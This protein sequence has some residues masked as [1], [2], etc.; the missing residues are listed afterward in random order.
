MK[1]RDLIHFEAVTEVI[2]LVSADKKETAK[3][4]IETYVIS[5]RMADVILHRM[6]PNLKLDHTSK[7][8]GLLIVGNYGTG[9]SHLMSVITSIAEHADLLDSIR[10]PA[11]REELKSIAGKFKV[12]R[13]ETSALNVSLRDIVFSQLSSHLK[14]MGVQY[15]FP[16]SNQAV[17]NK[18]SLSDM[19]EKFN[20]VYPGMGLLIALD[21][22][23]DF[24]RAKDEKA[25]INDLNFLR[26]VGEVCETVPLRFIAGIQE[27]LFDNPRF[28]FVADSIQR[29]KSRFDQAAI[30]REDI[31]YVVSHRL[32]SKTSDQLVKIRKHLEKFTPLYAEMAERLDSFVELF[33]VHPAYL[34]VFEQVTIGE[35][36]ELLKALSQEM[37]KLLENDVPEDEPGL[38][39]YDSYWRMIAEDNAFRAIPDVRNVLDKTTVLGE[40]VRHAPETKD[41][42]AAAL[43]II[44]GLALHRLTVSDIYA[45]IGITPA[46]IR[47]RLCISLPIPEKDADFLLATV[48]TV[49]KAVSTAVNGQYISH[50]RENDQYY[51][52][53]KKDIDYDALITQ[54]SQ[55]LDKSTIDRYYFDVLVN[56]LEI[57]DSSYVP[58][59]RIWE[60]EIPW[61]GHGISRRGYIF[62]G[63]SNERSTAHPERDFYIHFLGIYGNGHAGLKPQLDEIYYSLA[64]E[65]EFT[66]QLKLYA[67]AVEMS[68]ISSGSNK[69]QY[70][71]KAQQNKT[72]LT[73]WLRENF[74][75]SFKVSHLD[76][77]FS[78]P[79]A[80]ALYKTAIRDTNFRDQVFALSSAML[81]PAFTDKFPQYPSFTGLDLTS[82]TLGSAAEAAIKAIGS[83]SAIRLAQVVL[84]GL[85]LGHFDN[86]QMKWTIESSPYASYYLD[87]V[88]K[89]KPG[90]VVNRLDLVEGEPGAERDRQ[91]RLEPELLLVVLLAVMRQGGLTL[92]IQGRHVFEPGQV[93]GLQFSLDQMMRFTSIS[94]PKPLPEQAIKELLT[95][96]GIDANILDDPGALTLGVT[97]LQKNIQDEM[98]TV[99]KLID[100]LRDGP[101]FWGELVLSKEEQLNARN[102]LD[103]Y[104]QFLTG[105]QSHTTPARL[106]NL[107]EGVGEIR[108]AVKTRNVVRDLQGIFAILNDLRPAWDYLAAAQ[109]L[110]PQGHAWQ[111]EL[112]T[113]RE[114]VVKTLSDGQKRAATGTS[115]QLRARLENVKASYARQYYEMHTAARLDR[116]QDEQKKAI[117]ADPRWVKMR[118]LSKLSL[119]PTRQLEEVQ[120]RIAG[121]ATCPNLQ[122]AE[123]KN[124]THCPQCGFNPAAAGND[125]GRAI[126]RLQEASAAFEV[127]CKS[128]VE[129]LLE[130][131]QSEEA[132]HN[133]LLVAENE[134]Q[135]VKEFLRTRTLPDPIKETF[136]SGVENTLQGLEVIAVD[137][138]DY[139]LALTQPGM[140]CT[141]EEL[142]KRIREFLQG[143]LEGK[144]RRK[145]R[146]QINW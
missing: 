9:K 55:T 79:E 17:T 84:E 21:E 136:L 86:G 16:A 85:Q 120:D 4:L 78:I 47:D 19:M 46:E 31:A 130:N 43:R 38:I 75:R 83:G 39:T 15:E 87:L 6:I 5:N 68:A 18:Q 59:F 135:A 133:L 93:G 60:L 27:A 52:D 77:T 116:S 66:D 132:Q 119:L 32:L 71:I 113:A 128:W 126:T 34:E 109:P 131:L 129:V 8:R 40:K 143:I 100:S 51:L 138:A 82:Q 137:G 69:D 89:L 23:L 105:L 3:R 122:P 76:K 90:Q 58:G 139:L 74:V 64:E 33:P 97:Q 29:V 88:N 144:D 81:A 45:P 108:A 10:H 115:D 1:Y 26:E 44:D 20:Q 118:A 106:A 37:Q 112:N 14:K 125:Q 70:E 22:L 101:K 67:G 57:K 98:N 12:S 61:A 103:K 73:R 42:R 92:N 124:H 104:R 140:P 142:E 114:H 111:A 13:Q 94:K 96:F 49:L 121:V 110:M 65:Q 25:L 145:V 53:L 102:A 2:Q 48:E 127:L 28:Q 50:N 99:V 95:Q 30:V 107:L 11:I 24:L 62:L 36:R 41:F 123:M 7:S 141:P 134:H 54:K 63:S 91:F 146:I 117:T 56:G 72:R 80:G 35:R